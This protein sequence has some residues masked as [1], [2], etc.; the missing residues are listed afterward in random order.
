MVKLHGT[1]HDITERKR[2]EEDL[3]R[4][5]QRLSLATESALIGIW[6]LDVQ[7]NVLLWDKRMYELYGIRLEDFSGPYEVWKKG[8]H[9]DDVV[10]ADAEVKDAIAGTGRLHTQFR[11]VWPDGQVRHIEAHAMVQHGPDGTPR[12]LIGVNWDITERKRAEEEVKSQLKELTR[13]QDVMLGREDR[14]QELK[15][16]VNELSRRLAEPIRYPSQ[17]VGPADPKAVEPNA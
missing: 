5:A 15:R 1:V 9:P 10:T 11:V 12:R 3:H 13:W 16:E 2:A 14:V 6:D 7:N 4:I 17:E 8:V